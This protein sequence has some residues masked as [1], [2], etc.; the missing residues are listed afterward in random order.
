MHDHNLSSTADDH[1]EYGI[2]V[3]LVDDQAIIGEAVRRMFAPY[4]DI[5]FNFVA[6]AG[7][8]LAS[9]R[10]FRPTVILQDL[11]MPGADGFALLQGYREDPALRDVPVVMLSSMEEPLIKA[12]GFALG[13]SDYLVKLPD[14]VEL[15]A[16]VR[17]HSRGCISA[18][19]RDAAF[20]S[21]R[22]SR[23]ELARVNAELRNLVALDGLTGIGNRRRFDDALAQEFLRGRRQTMPLAV[24]LC[25][26]D[27]FKLYNDR[28]GHP[29][30]DQCLKRVAAV[31][32]GQLQRPGDLAARY[33]GEEFAVLLPET[34]LAGAMQVAGRLLAGLESLALPH[35]E[36]ARGLVTM[37]VGAACV[38]PGAGT[39]AQDLIDSADAALYEAKRGG[40]NRVVAA[41]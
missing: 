23:E 28:F 33:G 8:A 1:N 5:E 18:R 2:R 27:H 25:D 24:L 11:V 36:T 39:V 12:N 16:R 17:H 21:L 34:D 14:Q 26:V 35:P 20:A 29:A 3:L 9:A 30:G 32:T 15:L 19:Q 6:D 37:S 13:A 38:H 40:R 22:E 7:A 31:L 10:A 41:T 4:P